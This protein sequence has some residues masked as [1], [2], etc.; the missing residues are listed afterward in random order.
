MCF[1]RWRRSW[2]GS[3]WGW[4]CRSFQANHR[5]VHRRAFGHVGLAAGD[6][7]VDVS[8]VRRCTWPPS[9]IDNADARLRRP[10]NGDGKL[11]APGLIDQED[12]VALGEALGGGIVGMERDGSR[13]E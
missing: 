13:P 3:R 5:A 9:F 2:L 4:G 11:Q 10:R 7:H 8:I 12:A 6:K 1:R